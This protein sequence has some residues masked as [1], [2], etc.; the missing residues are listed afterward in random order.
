MSEAYDPLSRVRRLLLAETR[1]I[2]WWS[3]VVAAELALVT[4]YVA[5][6]D[7]IVTEP[8]YV[9]YPFVWINVGLWAGRIAEVLSRFTLERIRANFELYRRRAAEQTIRKPGAWLHEAITEG[10]ALEP[11][12]EDGSGEDGLGEAPK[13]GLPAL[14]HKE[15]VSEAKKDAYVAQGTGEERFHRCPSGRDNSGERRYMYFDPEVGGPKRRT[16]S[17]QS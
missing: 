9:V 7:V 8:R 4:A 10:Y 11:S 17:V 14:K 16:R 1:A 15:T 13:G 2:R 5:V 6:T 12:G 3:L